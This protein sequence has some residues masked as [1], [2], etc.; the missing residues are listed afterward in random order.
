M[1]F[2]AVTL[3]TYVTTTALT[4]NEILYVPLISRS[5]WRFVRPRPMLQSDFDLCEP[6][7]PSQVEGGVVSQYRV[8]KKYT[9]Q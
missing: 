5:D 7:N 4:T 9:V 2:W 6:A 8:F 1:F 3:V